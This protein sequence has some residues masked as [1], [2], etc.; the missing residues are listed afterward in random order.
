MMTII[1][2]VR[3]IHDY[4]YH[5]YNYYDNYYY[6]DY[7]DYHNY[8]HYHYHYHYYHYY[9][10]YHYY[11]NYYYYHDFFS[12]NLPRRRHHSM[13]MKLQLSEQQRSY[14]TQSFCSKTHSVIYQEVP[15]M[16]PTHHQHQSSATC[17]IVIVHH[18]PFQ[19]ANIRQG[20]RAPHVLE[21][22]V[23]RTLEPVIAAFA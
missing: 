3:I 4:N 22:K 18:R 2:I 7:Y 1:I 5:N 21:P 16:M 9:Y 6:H 19:S 12:W 14:D 15:S 10:H 20:R 11:D 23:R 13:M 8:Y 17:V